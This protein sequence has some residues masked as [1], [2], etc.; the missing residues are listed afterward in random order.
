MCQCHSEGASG[1]CTNPHPCPA[2]LARMEKEEVQAEA[3]HDG[4]EKLPALWMP[5][6]LCALWKP[7]REDSAG[8]AEDYGICPRRIWPQNR[9]QGIDG[10]GAGVMAHD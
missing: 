2:C 3:G 10:C 5:C 6:Y 8:S 4:G 9:T 1:P 7:S